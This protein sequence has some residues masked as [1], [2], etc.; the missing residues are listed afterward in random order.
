MSGHE[1]SKRFLAKLESEGFL[2]QKETS[3]GPLSVDFYGCKNVRYGLLPYYLHYYVFQLTSDLWPSLQYV[4]GLHALVRGFT[5]NFKNVRSKWYR[6]RVPITVTL[7][8]SENGYDEE[9]ILRIRSTKQRYQM[10]DCNTIILVDISKSRIYML[11]RF[12]FIGSL[13][14]KRVNKYTCSLLAEI[15]L[16]E[17]GKNGDGT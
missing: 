15:G 13:P 10:G 16:N 12:G 6:F 3:L 4:L 7:I 11:N 9:T 5:D 1:L 14:L 17:Y 8:I 2:C